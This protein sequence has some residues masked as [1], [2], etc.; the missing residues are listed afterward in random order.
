[1]TAIVKEMQK[2]FDKY[3][4]EYS[5]I[6]SCA[7]ILDPCDKVKFVK[8]CYTKVYG[9]EAGRYTSNVCNTLYKCFETYKNNRAS[10]SKYT[11]N[12]KSNVIVNDD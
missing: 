4:S 2:Q 3:Q 7:V 11:M 5:L 12:N 6:L 9:M 8:F 1:M 10:S